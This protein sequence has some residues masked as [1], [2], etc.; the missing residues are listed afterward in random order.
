[1]DMEMGLSMNLDM[2]TGRVM[3]LEMD[4]DLYAER[5]TEM[6]VDLAGEMDMGLGSAGKSTD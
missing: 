1:M 4:L 6:E 3:E 2:A 5:G